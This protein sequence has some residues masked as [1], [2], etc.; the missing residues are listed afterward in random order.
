MP[1]NEGGEMVLFKKETKK[2]NVQKPE[3]VRDGKIAFLVSY[4]AVR[5]VSYLLGFLPG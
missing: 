3:Q 4:S 1:A 2:N 5:L